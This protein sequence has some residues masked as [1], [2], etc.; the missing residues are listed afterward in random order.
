MGITDLELLVA[1]NL[2][3]GPELYYAVQSLLKV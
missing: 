1:T 2:Q 3:G